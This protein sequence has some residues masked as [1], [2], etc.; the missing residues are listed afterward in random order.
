MNRAEGASPGGGLSS[1]GPAIAVFNHGK[2]KSTTMKENI[3]NL[4]TII[5]PL[6]NSINRSPLRRAF[7]L[8]SLALAWLALLPAPNAFGVSPAPDGDYSGN[9]TAEG[10]NALF[11]LTTGVLLA[12]VQ[13][14]NQTHGQSERNYL[15]S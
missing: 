5:L 1:F 2:K 4:K 10:T 13:G 7:L 12:P 6:R 8:V 11:S 3:I 9:N 14:R 15:G